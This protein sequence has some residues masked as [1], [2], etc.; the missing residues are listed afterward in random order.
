M[1][2]EFGTTTKHSCDSTINGPLKEHISSIAWEKTSEPLKNVSVTLTDLGIDALKWTESWRQ[3]YDRVKDNPDLDG[4]ML[5][6]FANAIEAGIQEGR[7]RSFDP[8]RDIEEFHEKFGL[9]YYGPPRALPP[10]MDVFRRKLIQEEAD[11]YR[12][13][14]VPLQ[15]AIAK[16]A[17]GPVTYHLEQQLDALVDLTYVTLGTS[18]LHGFNFRE[19]WRRV[20]QANMMKVRALRASDSKRG[21]TYDVVKPEGWKPPSHVDL[22][23]DHIHRHPESG[24]RVD[25]ISPLIKRRPL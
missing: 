17:A 4:W 24:P 6:W 23:E 20:H 12:A 10:D 18:Y 19:A 25:N 16:Y 14:V 5:G 3:V 21:S 11:E 22:V 7:R 1:W 15:G 9:Q 2:P 13:H 8:A